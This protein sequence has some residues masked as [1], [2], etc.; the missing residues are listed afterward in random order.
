MV[1]KADQ[2]R[3]K[4]LLSETITLLCK[5]GLNFR[6]EFSI[7]GLIGITLDQE[8][9]FLVSIKETIRTALAE[10]AAV[11]DS[12]GNKS[13]SGMNVN[14]AGAR[15]RRERD[16]EVKK[17]SSPPPFV[18]T[19]ETDGDQLERL[20]PQVPAGDETSWSK[21]STSLAASTSGMTDGISITA[22]SKQER[23]GGDDDTQD[24]EDSSTQLNTDLNLTFS[25]IPLSSNT[26]TTDDDGFDVSRANKR[27][28]LQSH[29]VGSGSMAGSAVRASAA[30]GSAA[31]NEASSGSGFET[32]QPRSTNELDSNVHNRGSDRAKLE[33]SDI[34]EI[35]DELMSGGEGE[36][37]EG[38][39]GDESYADYSG[40]YEGMYETGD[41]GEGEMNMYTGAD[42]G[43]MNMGSGSV[44]PRRRSA[45]HGNGGA[46]SRQDPVSSLIFL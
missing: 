4:A 39:E 10:A 18:M 40:E 15:R 44:V 3:V 9:I 23:T 21:V 16:V 28:R 35:K 27:R 30:I 17:P 22:T 31:S 37:E 45:P 20:Q 33:H 26:R 6:K 41:Q 8:E 5:N 13:V 12:G 24:V 46:S 38:A 42:G 29:Q 1:L 19:V 2:Q 11:S 34:I 32:F 14:N 36:E 25:N 7:E 43:M